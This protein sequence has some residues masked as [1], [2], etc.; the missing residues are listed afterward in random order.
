[1]PSS[2]L[3]VPSL[4]IL[5]AIPLILRKVPQNVLY[6]FRTPKTMSN[7]TI[8]YA[9]NWGAGWDMALAGAAML[10]LA[11]L[12]PWVG[13]LDAMKPGNFLAVVQLPLLLLGVAHSFWRL[14]KL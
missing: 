12:K 4:L 6:G 2:N 1:M 3:L 9:A 13:T 14:R 8:W 7:D 11:A 10:A 5:L